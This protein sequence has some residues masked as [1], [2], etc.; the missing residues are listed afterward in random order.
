[1]MLS[2]SGYSCDVS[3]FHEGYEPRHNVEIVQAATAFQ[4]PD[5]PIVY[6]VMGSALWFGE[7]L[8]HTLFNGLL[9]RDA[10][11]ALSTNPHDRHEFFGIDLRK[12]DAGIDL[13]IP[14]TRRGNVIGA[15]TF[16]P[17]RDKVL[18]AIDQGQPNVV[19]L[20]PESEY[21]ATSPIGISSADCDTD[22]R[23]QT[24]DIPFC[25]DAMY[26][27]A[28]APND[29]AALFWP[30]QIHQVLVG[31]AHVL[32]SAPAPGTPIAGD[33][34]PGEH[35]YPAIF[36]INTSGR[37]HGP[38][39]PELLQKQSGIGFETA[40]RT[41]EV[42]TQLALRHAVHPLRRRYRTDLL[43]LNM[44]QINEIIHTDT[45]YSK[46]LSHAGNKCAQI[47][48]TRSGLVIIYPI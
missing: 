20:N 17:T 25:P 1:M 27:H 8:P 48:V 43:S 6:I 31:K 38:V 45:I 4:H 39:T 30:H 18:H 11:V 36:G 46:Y 40:Q 7:E 13:R 32:D 21:Q 10:G 28:V 37:H 41:I 33:G 5:G 15:Q 19:F 9:A 14:F 42:T 44:R 29:E 3:P 26:H 12:S 24:G 23:P 47:F 2:T 35:S 22:H 34:N 16:R